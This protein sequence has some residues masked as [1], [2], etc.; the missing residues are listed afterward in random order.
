MAELHGSET[1]TSTNS[2]TSPLPSTFTI[3]KPNTSFPDPLQKNQKKRPRDNSSKHPVYRG[4]RMRAWGKWVSEI[5]EPRK[6]NRIWLG[7]FATPEMAARAHDAAAMVIK[8]GSAI[9]NFPEIAGSLL[10]PDSNS[11]RDVQAAAAK[12]AAM[13]VLES[14]TTLHLSSSCA[15]LRSSNSFCRSSEEELGKIVEL[16]HL[17]TSFE[18]LDLGNNELVFFDTVEGWP[19]SHPWYHNIYDGGDNISVQD[20][21][22]ESVML[23]G[24]EGS[25]WEH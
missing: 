14:Q 10:R 18:S 15:S 2:T 19:Y 7:T 22:S 23:C 9:L 8:G 17:G 16:P 11:P 6:K 3:T 24:F 13:E 5:R 25:F 1:D 12:A 20:Y 21:Y 4:V